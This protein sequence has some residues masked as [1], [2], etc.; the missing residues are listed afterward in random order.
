MAVKHSGESGGQ[1]WGSDTVV[2]QRERKEVMMRVR[3][4]G[5]STLQ[6]WE[7][8]AVMRAKGE[9]GCQVGVR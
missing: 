2:W 9:E 4:S 6:G 3:H 5:D 8:D 7:S 1:G